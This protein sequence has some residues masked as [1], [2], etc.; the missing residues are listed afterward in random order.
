MEKPLIDRVVEQN[1]LTLDELDAGQY[2]VRIQTLGASGLS[3]Q[4]T[5]VQ[6]FTVESRFDWRY[7]LL[8]L[9]ILLL[10]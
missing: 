3:S 9:P 6:S 1:S 4:W 5:N 7:L 10:L 2:F 8:T